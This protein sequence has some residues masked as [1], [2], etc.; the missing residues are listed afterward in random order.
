MNYASGLPG[1]TW[2][3]DA[4]PPAPPAESNGLLSYLN[5]GLS[6]YVPLRSSERSN[7][8]EAY[9]SL[10]HWE[11]CVARLTQVPRL[12][13]VPGRERDLLPVLLLLSRAADPRAAAT[14]ICARIYPGQCAVHGGVRRAP[15]SRSFAVLSGPMAQLRH[16]MS[17]GRLPFSVAYVSSMVGTLYFALGPRWRLVTF[18]FALIQ[19]VALLFYL[20]AYFP[21]GV[22]TLRYAGSMLA[23]GGSSLLPL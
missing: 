22:T 11:R 7:E 2:G 3:R 13:C 16:L 6:G 20:A 23:R 10:S 18:L 21:G 5:S 8:E 1:W 17:P 9:L 4:A 15:R 12:S 14:Q 19:L